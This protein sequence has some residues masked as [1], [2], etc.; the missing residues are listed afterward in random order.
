MRWRATGL[1]AAA[2]FFVAGVVQS[3][4]MASSLQ[5]DPRNII[6]LAGAG[7]DTVA[8]FAFFPETVRI[9]ARDTVTWQPNDDGRHTISFTMGTAPAGPTR[10]NPWVPPG[11]VIPF[12]AVPLPE[13]P[14][15]AVMRNPLILYPTSIDGS[16]ETYSGTGYINSGFLRKEPLFP[17]APEVQSFSLRFDTP[18]TYP[19]ICLLHPERMAGVVEV[20]PASATDLPSQAA[21]DA[22][23]RAE[24]AVILQQVERS[25]EAASTARTVPGPEDSSLWMVRTGPSMLPA[26]DLRVQFEEFLPR[27]LTVTAGDTVFWESFTPHTVT[28]IP[29]PPAP[30]WD[31]YERGPNGT[32]R[33]VRDMTLDTPARPSA[34]YDP[35]QFFN[36][37]NINYASPRGSSWALTFEQPGT[38]EYFCAIHRDRGMVGTVTVMPR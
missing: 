9:R 4:T 11:E 19:Y 25:R 32:W 13:G 1:L 21:V 34:T 12:P 36:S 16:V 30:E 29:T 6:V 2:A 31:S 26:F 5:Q 3:A 27:D 8:A 18:G 10:S 38:F 35:T 7:Q 23:A 24:M 33:E 15:G 37:G 28:F 20:A 22:R 17:G 14:P